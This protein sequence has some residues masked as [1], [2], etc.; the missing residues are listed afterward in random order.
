MIDLYT[1]NK[2]MDTK[3]KNTIL[4]I[5]IQ[6]IWILRYNSN[7]TC[8]RLVCKNHTKPMKEIKDLNI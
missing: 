8:T 1:D 4:F 3:I 2:Y 7:K 5:I 6:K